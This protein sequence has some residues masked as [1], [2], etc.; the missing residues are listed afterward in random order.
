MADFGIRVSEEGFDVKTTPS[1]VNKKR[2]IFL[3]DDKSPIIYYAGF[4]EE[5]SPGAG[6]SYS[7]NLG[8]H[9]LYFMFYV[10]S[11][12]NPTYYQAI[13]ASTTTTTIS[14]TYERAYVIILN[15]GSS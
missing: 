4:L 6:V 15:E 7:H 1:D 5:T 12:S 11:V 10:D 2:F 9:P 3:S 14:S 13:K 8:R